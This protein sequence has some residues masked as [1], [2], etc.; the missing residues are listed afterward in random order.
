[1]CIVENPTP[2]KVRI[3]YYCF[4]S[5]T[6]VYTRRLT[7]SRGV[8]CTS[9]HT[10]TV[11]TLLSARPVGPPPHVLLCI[12]RILFVAFIIINIIIVVVVVASFDILYENVDRVW[13]PVGVSNSAPYT[14]TQSSS[15][16]LAAVTRSR[17]VIME[18]GR[19][20]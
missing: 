9:E 11:Y 14:Y 7:T 19:T 15:G 10:H 5:T 18:L 4:L 8:W 16:Q 13:V 3:I 1:M 6:Q 20:I 12:R 2:I 17:A